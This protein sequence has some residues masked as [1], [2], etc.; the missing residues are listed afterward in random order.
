MKSESKTELKNLSRSDLTSR[1]Q[2]SRKELLKLRVQ[3]A[4]GA[5]ASTGKVRG[6][7]K[8]IARMMALLAGKEQ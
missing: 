4:A 8:N 5:S 2:E 3:L 7:K 6:V 1:L